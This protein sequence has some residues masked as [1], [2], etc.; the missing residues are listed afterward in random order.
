MAAESRNSNVESVGSN[1][2]RILRSTR[3]PA[4][5]TNPVQDPDLTDS[6]ATVRVTNLWQN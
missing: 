6:L 3:T 5:A 4:N 1:P 2:N